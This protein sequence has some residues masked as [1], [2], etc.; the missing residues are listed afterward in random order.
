MD[1]YHCVPA[2]AGG[3]CAG[4]RLAGATAAAR[5]GA[6]SGIHAD[7]SNLPGRCACDRIGGRRRCARRDLCAWLSAD[8]VIPEIDSRDIGDPMPDAISNESQSTLLHGFLGLADEWISQKTDDRGIA[9][10]R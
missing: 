8:A 5:C 7:R 10:F 2:A 9:W 1:R 3:R 4:D 6:L